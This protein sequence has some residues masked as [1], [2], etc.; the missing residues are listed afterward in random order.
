MS[1]SRWRA[2]WDEACA[3]EAQALA[4][5][6]PHR[7]PLAL[8]AASALT[9]HI[10]LVLC[11]WPAFCFP[12]FAWLPLLGLSAC[13]PGFGIGCGRTRSAVAGC[14]PLLAVQALLLTV[15]RP[16]PT[17]GQ[18]VAVTI[19]VV[20]VSVLLFIPLGHV[21]GR[22]MLRLPFLRASVLCVLG[23]L[24]GVAVSALLSLLWTP[25]NAV[26]A[27]AWL[28]AVPLLSGSACRPALA[29]V[30]V[31]TVTVGLMAPPAGQ[32]DS[33]GSIFI[34]LAPPSLGLCALAVV[35]ARKAR[36]AERPPS[37]AAA[38]RAA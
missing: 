30:S 22:L 18:A 28:G 38:K 20:V 26:W 16:L 13:I 25:P 2:W 15:C 1:L 17:S 36:R 21:H 35:S 5:L 10:A 11:R 24:L 23:G 27:L 32:G 34:G 33:G 37:E 3:A 6:P 7:L 14:L 4:A 19:S 31:L 12:A 29:T 8:V 9:I